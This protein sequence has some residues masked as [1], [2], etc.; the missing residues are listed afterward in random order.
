MPF[1][2]LHC[3]AA[4]AQLRTRVASRARA[5]VDAS[6]A[7]PQVLERQLAGYE[8]LDASERACVLDAVTDE[9]VDLAALCARWMAAGKAA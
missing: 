2:I 1:S 8:P 7:T 3:H 6:E 4:P 9:A 5:G